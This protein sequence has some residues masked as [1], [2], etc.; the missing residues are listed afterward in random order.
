MST[1]SKDYTIQVVEIQHEE[2]LAITSKLNLAHGRAIYHREARG[3]E[4][5][6]TAQVKGLSFEIII[7][8]EIDVFHLYGRQCSHSHYG[9]GYANPTG[10]KT[11]AR[12]QKDS[13][14]TGESHNVFSKK[15]RGY[16]LYKIEEGKI[17]QKTLWQSDKPI[18]VLK[19]HNGDGMKELTERSL[20]ED[21]TVRLRTGERLS[22]KPEPKTCSSVDK[23]D[24]LK[25]RMRE[26][27]T[28][29]SVREFIVN[30]KRRWL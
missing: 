21:T 20:E 29:G 7:V 8:S 9:Q 28:H 6:A 25:N 1:P 19:S 12:Y 3:M 17:T 16:G 15:D 5:W 30:S 26:I 24:F 13:G 23:E 10:S 22:P 14:G 11:V 4:Y 27:C 18:V 2:R